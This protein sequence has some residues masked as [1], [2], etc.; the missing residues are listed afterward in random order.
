M[1]T[2]QTNRV[3]LL[4]E[5]AIQPLIEILRIRRVLDDYPTRADR[6]RALAAG[7]YQQRDQPLDELPLDSGRGGSGNS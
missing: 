3:A 6:V 1:T 4:H 7:V 5:R 2:I